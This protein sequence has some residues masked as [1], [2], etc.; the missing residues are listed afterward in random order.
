MTETPTLRVP[1]VSSALFGQRI[2]PR[3]SDHHSSLIA[4]L[5]NQTTDEATASYSSSPAGDRTGREPRH[6]EDRSRAGPALRTAL[7]PPPTRP[8]SAQRP[9]RARHRRHRPRRHPIE[10]TSHRTDSARP[11]GRDTRSSE[12]G[13]NRSSR[14]HGAADR[15]AQRLPRGRALRPA[16]RRHP[17][18][19]PV[20]VPDQRPRRGAG[21]PTRDNP[22]DRK[23]QQRQL[24]IPAGQS[25]PRRHADRSG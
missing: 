21:T 17:R 20:A 10:L 9:L 16:R 22:L 8:R 7:P 5:P 19:A 14:P 13:S 15:L 2:H 23:A 18:A 1:F 4:Q 3:I 12:P 25:S 11:H 24:D 6:H